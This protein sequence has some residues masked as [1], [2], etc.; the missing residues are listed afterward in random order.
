MSSKAFSK[1]IVEIINSSKNKDRVESEI[2]HVFD[3]LSSHKEA[4]DVFRNFGMPQEKKIEAMNKLLGK[5]VDSMTWDLI[6]LTISQGYGDNLK[7]ISR[8]VAEF[9]AEKRGAAVAEVVSAIELDEGTQKSIKKVLKKKFG[10][11]VELK[12]QIDKG[13]LGGLRVSVGERT[14]DGLVSTSLS[15]IKSALGGR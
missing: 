11:N 12:M 9:L 14:F 10:R 3:I 13:V 15:E 4:L 6:A 5:R 7:D 8:H 1:G 2:L